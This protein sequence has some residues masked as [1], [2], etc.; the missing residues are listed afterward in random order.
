MR[1][2][3]FVFL[4]CTLAKAKELTALEKPPVINFQGVR[5][6]LQSP[7]N[8][9]IGR[10]LSQLP[11]AYRR[12]FALQ[13]KSFSN[14]SATFKYPRIIFFGPDAK[15]LMGV[16]GNPLDVNFDTVEFIEYEPTNA[17]Y[18]F[19]S[20][21]FEKEKEPQVLENPAQC[22]TCHG[23]DPKPNWESYSLWPGSYGSLHDR[24]PYG[25]IEN[26]EFKT[27]IKTYQ[28]S[29]RYQSL[30][31][32]FYMANGPSEEK[33]DYFMTPGGVG[34]GSAL[35]ILANFL[36]RDRIAKKIA[37][38]PMHLFYRSAITAALLGCEGSIEDYL[39][40]EMR[41]NQK[42]TFPESE[43]NLT[44]WYFQ[45]FER[46]IRVS[47]EYLGVAKEFIVPHVSTSQQRPEEM[48]RIARLRYL[49]DDRK[50]GALG[51]SQWSLSISRTAFDFE[52]GAHGLE[53]LI[54]HYIPL[55]YSEEEPLRKAIQ[56]KST[57]FVFTSLKV[58]NAPSNPENSYPLETFQVAPEIRA[59]VCPQLKF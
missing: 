31:K 16:S 59:Q 41:M 39:S 9:E 6:L 29:P 13:Y 58:V 47:Q 55:A 28:A 46:R 4:F 11:V 5:K 21:H 45:N 26:T 33:Q 20:V 50:V 17:R 57:P 40:P 48:L 43:S 37:A 32:P 1:Y 49:L 12:H 2:W 22:L 24:I 38:S 25:S 3:I 18:R 44:E 36:N 14:H 15:L 8:W 42:R 19:Y 34:S 52:D 30:V 35:S 10:F 53:N 23:G 54:G 51:F 27:F 56:I 7:A